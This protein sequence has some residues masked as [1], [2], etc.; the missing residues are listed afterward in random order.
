MLEE[1]ARDLSS[2]LLDAISSLHSFPI[3]HRDIKPENLLLKSMVN[4]T[5]IKIADFGFACKVSTSSKT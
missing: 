4:D 2:N 1:Q 3:A 5:D